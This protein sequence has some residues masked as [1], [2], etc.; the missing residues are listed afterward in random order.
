MINK[1]ETCPLCLNSG[2][3]P[4]GKIFYRCRSCRAVVNPAYKPLEYNDSYF[5]EEYLNQ[6]GVTYFEDYNNIYN[7]SA[8]RIKNILRILRKTGKIKPPEPLSDSLSLLDIGSAAG[9]FLKCARDNGFHYVKGVEISEFAAK[10]SVDRFGF[11]IE[12]KP[13]N[14]V[15]IGINYDA[16]TA[17][18]YIE[19]S[20]DPLGDFK[21]IYYSLKRGGVFAFSVPSVF[22]PM[23]LFK[24]EEWERT[25][26]SDHYVDFSPETAVKI[27]KNVGFRSITVRA[28]GVH[29]ERL[30]S[31]SSVFFP[32][33]SFLYARL[34]RFLTFSDTI[35][36]Y[37]VK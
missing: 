29:P 12:V 7:L 19:H 2:L 26:P 17:W 37:A 35:E 18:Y 9:F 23:F 10:Y 28:A 24:R 32:V 5:T 25:H 4:C 16:I 21:R 14:R 13:F 27:L 36:V 15:N 34:S 33:I 11:D 1:T 22:G 8:N 30:F 6:Y 31:P 20:P 3:Y